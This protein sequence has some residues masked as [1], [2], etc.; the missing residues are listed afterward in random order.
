MLSKVSFVPELEFIETISVYRTIG[1]SYIEGYNYNY[2]D[3]MET[4]TKNACLKLVLELHRHRITHGDLQP[5]NFIVSKSN[6]N[7]F[8][9]HILFFFTRFF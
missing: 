8:K 2:F 4:V 5:W 6:R 3:E 1:M 7:I 9:M